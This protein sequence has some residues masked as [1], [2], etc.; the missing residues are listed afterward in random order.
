M[1]LFRAVRRYKKRLE[2]QF[3]RQIGRKQFNF[4]CDQ[5]IFLQ[6]EA[7][8]RKL[9]VPIYP[10][11]EHLLQIGLESCLVEARDDTRRE[12]LQ[13]HLVHDH[14]L[15]EG[16]NPV[17]ERTSQQAYRIQAALKLVRLAELKGKSPEGIEGIIDRLLGE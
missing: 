11:A 10:L 14:L 15:V 5:V 4:A 16:L 12:L 9:E 13:R 8:A 7:L 17:S 1:Q 2:K 3:T 6:L